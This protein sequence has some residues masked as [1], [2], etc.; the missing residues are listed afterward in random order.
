MAIRYFCDLC[1]REVER[2]ALLTSI[3]MQEIE[4]EDARSHNRHDMHKFINRVNHDICINCRINIMEH[5]KS[6]IDSS[7]VKEG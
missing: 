5:I 2:K 1:N 7:K 3:L 4:P 6:I